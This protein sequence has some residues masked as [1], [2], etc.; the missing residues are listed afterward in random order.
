MPEIKEPLYNKKQTIKKIYWLA[1]KFKNDLDKVYDITDGKNVPVSKIP[2]IDFY[3]IVKNI[4]YKRDTDPVEV[5]ARPRIIF[6]NYQRGIG[7][8]CKKAAVLFGA[9]FNKNGIAWRL[10]TV[11]TRPDKKIHHIFTQADIAGSG[12][13]LNVDGT[14]SYMKPFQKKLVTKYEVY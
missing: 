4:P 11:S 6:E 9:W 7:K 8:D 5:V 1:E 13:F 3:N 10:V 2:F 12:D 14:Y